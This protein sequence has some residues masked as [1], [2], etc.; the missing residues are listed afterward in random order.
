MDDSRS[1]DAEADRLAHEAQAA[2]APT[3]W[4]EELWSAAA[5]DEVDMPW[6]R[7]DPYPP[8]V[9]HLDRSGPGTGRRAVVVGAGLGADAEL[10][11]SHGY[12]TTAFD[13]APTAVELA[14]SRHPGTAVDYRVADLLDLP[15]DLVEA[16]DLVV[17][18]F[19]VQALPRALRPRAVA[20]VRSLLAPGG[21]LLSANFVLADG[22]D[23]EAGP[24][25]LLSRAE[26]E[27][28]A[29]DDVELVS[30]AREPHPLSPAGPPL[31]VGVFRRRPAH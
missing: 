4:F 19:T 20:G 18:V 23:P 25:W 11:A 3:R 17:D 10:L 28:H 31:W 14:R 12:A 29:D 16:F 30:L 9:A 22:A 1:W 2:G 6:D 26:M 7:R 21:E 5:R 27:G 13:L 8:V 15:D 24:P